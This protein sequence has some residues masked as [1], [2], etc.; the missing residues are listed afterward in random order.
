MI[1]RMS[2]DA[3]GGCPQ[4]MHD[5]LM[6]HIFPMFSRVRTVEELRAVAASKGCELIVADNKTLLIDF[7]SPERALFDEYLALAMEK[8]VVPFSSCELEAWR[9]RSGNW[10][11]K[12]TMP[13]RTSRVNIIHRG[14]V[15]IDQAR[16]E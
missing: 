8:G 6:D 13:V 12:I 7:D 4:E 14:D 16:D 9:S 15:H 10:H 3:C 1:D 11:F 2:R 5:Y